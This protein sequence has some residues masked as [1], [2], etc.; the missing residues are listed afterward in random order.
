[1]VKFTGNKKRLVTNFFSLSSVE[2][3]NYIF[4]LIT[5]PYLVRILG[6][7]KYG[8][9]AF[10]QVFVQYFIMISDYGFNMS[11]TRDISINRGDIEKVSLI[12]SSVMF[13]KLVLVAASFILMSLLI[14]TIDKFKPDWLLYY[15]TF[16]AAIGNM[17]FP[18]WLFQGMERMKFIASLNF[19]AKLIFV[20]TIFIFVKAQKDYLYVPLLTSLGFIVAGML[21]LWIAF[22]Y[23]KIKLKLPLLNE[24][25]YE[26]REGWHVFISSVSVSLYTTSNIF[27]LGIITNNTIV[28]YYSAADK[29]IRSG[30]RLIYPVFQS[31]YP[32]ISKL[33]VESRE[34]ALGIIKRMSILIGVGFLLVSTAILLLSKPIIYLILGAQYKESVSVLRILAFIPAVV[35][36]NTVFT[37]SFLL[38]FG[39]SR[40][41][42][43]IFI[44]S[45][46]LSFLFSTIFI[47]L[48]PLG[49]N[50]AAISWLLTECCV[51]VF[52]F[53][54]Y[55]ECSRNFLVKK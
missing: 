14:F 8:L 48:I 42:S 5:L 54:V 39:Y 33:A 24:I 30:I 46:F 2:A 44:L 25:R 11:A 6:P 40:E 3:A 43:K 1:M 4:P 23:F 13:I 49:S 29:L 10:A 15:L 17:L 20:F 51:L 50:G 41:A 19:L 31:I 37:N 38:G 32:F 7:E 55:R 28:G 47:Y 18:I 9:I 26:L 35:G 34:K 12:F 22:S 45:L 53:F 21:S 16:G 52:S 36:V 27:I